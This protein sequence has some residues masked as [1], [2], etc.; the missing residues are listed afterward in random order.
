MP[1]SLESCS[2]FRSRGTS[3]PNLDLLP[4]SSSLSQA[5]LPPLFL[6][7]ATVL[8]SSSPCSASSALRVE[9]SGRIRN[10]ALKR[11]REGREMDAHDG[12]VVRF[13]AG[14]PYYMYRCG[15]AVFCLFFPFLFCC[16]RVKKAY[17]KKP[18][19]KKT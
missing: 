10:G 2:P 11:D 19:K 17:K 7:L 5:L 13:E 12:T 16:S 6:L 3:P 18:S 14:G 9:G 4:L 1:F 15:G 8:S